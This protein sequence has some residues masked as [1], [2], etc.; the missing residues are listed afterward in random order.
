MIKQNKTNVNPQTQEAEQVTNR[1]N[2][3]KN[4]TQALCSQNADNEVKDKNLKRS[5]KK[6]MLYT[7][8]IKLDISSETMDRI[9]QYVLS[10][11][12]KYP[13]KT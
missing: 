4:H 10:T 12:K 2:I 13:P 3:K 5:Q 9:K 11:E 1:I 7:Y 6:N 8:K